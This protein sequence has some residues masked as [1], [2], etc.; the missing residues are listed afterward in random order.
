MGAS[1]K[2]N[3]V[4]IEGPDFDALRDAFKELPR[5]VA[6]KVIGAGLKRA[7]APM[8]AALKDVTPKGPTGNLRRSIKTVVKKYPR[9]GAAVAISVSKKLAPEEASPP[10]EGPSRKDQTERS[11][12]FGW[13]LEPKRKAIRNFLMR[14]KLQLPTP[15]IQ[16]SF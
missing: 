7:S 16:R 11:I 2:A 12:S 3:T 14:R 1:L 10:A 6:A 8:L 5:H 9:T 15:E 13:S 4:R